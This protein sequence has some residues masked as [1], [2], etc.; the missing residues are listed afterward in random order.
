M[1]QVNIHVYSAA[2]K[3]AQ[4]WA[5]NEGAAIAQEA[6]RRIANILDDDAEAWTFL[7]A[8]DAYTPGERL[9]FVIAGDDEF[10]RERSDAAEFWES[11]FGEPDPD[12]D[13]L[14]GFAAGLQA[15]LYP[16]LADHLMG[17]ATAPD[18][19][20]AAARLWP[21]L[22]TDSTQEEGNHEFTMEDSTERNVAN[23]GDNPF[24]Y[25]PFSDLRDLGSPIVFAFT[26]EQVQEF[27]TYNCDGPLTEVA[28]HSS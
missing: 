12:L 4:D 9:Y 18:D 7:L 1:N 27:A 6:A 21:R 16:T 25:L 24:R 26:A 28:V 8:Q 20:E 11:V 23:S 5:E 17:A 13:L 14:G 10:N 19:R 22:A 2:M 3:T 15:V